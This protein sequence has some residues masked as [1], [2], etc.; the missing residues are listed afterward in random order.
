M[1]WEGVSQPLP[2]CRGRG[3]IAGKLVTNVSTGGGGSSRT[4]RSPLSRGT[5]PTYTGA[6]QHQH[7][8]CF[9]LQTELNFVQQSVAAVCPLTQ[10]FGPQASVSRGPG[11]GPS[12]SSY[13]QGD[14]FVRIARMDG[15]LVCL[16]KVSYT[17]PCHTSCLT[18]LNCIFNA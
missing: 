7:A 11:T 17:K 13:G 5:R 6:A 8:V 4:H 9:E 16:S 18:F 14:V 10:V 12:Y 15:T 3:L 2:G 1:F